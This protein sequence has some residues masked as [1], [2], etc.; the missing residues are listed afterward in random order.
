M[1]GLFDVSLYN[2]N[3]FEEKRIGNIAFRWSKCNNHFEFVKYF[4][5]E[6][7]GN[8]DKYERD[9]SGNYRD[10]DTNCI[11]GASMFIN[12]EHCYT[13]AGFYLDDYSEPSIVSVGERI[14]DLEDK[15]CLD[16]K[17]LG[18]SVWDKYHELRKHKLLEYIKERAHEIDINQ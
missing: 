7:Y 13:I 14:F 8:E 10:R 9:Q 12:P 2:V 4:K 16:F 11:I 6:F 17:N 15:D 3:L 1:G 18:K 5:N